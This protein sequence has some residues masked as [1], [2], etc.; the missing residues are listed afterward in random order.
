MMAE[1]YLHGRIK[2]SV[3]SV[4]TLNQC[5]QCHWFIPCILRYHRATKRILAVYIGTQLKKKC[6]NCPTLEHHWRDCNSPHTQAHI[7]WQSSIHA[8]LKWQAG[9]TPSSTWT[10]LCKFYFYL[11]FAALQCIAVLLFKRV[12]TSKSL[13][14]CLGYEHHYSVSVIGVAVQMKSA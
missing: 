12:N 14:A 7:F 6:W 3:T 8:S 2:R 1:W 10:G 11:E 5:T 13:R 4:L 9:R